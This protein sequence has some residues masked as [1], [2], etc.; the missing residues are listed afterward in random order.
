MISP[1]NGSYLEKDREIYIKV[2]AN[3][4]LSKAWVEILGKKKINTSLNGSGRI[5]EKNISLEE[6]RYNIIA[7]G[8]DIAGNI[9]KSLLYTITVVKLLKLNATNI[10]A[11]TSSIIINTSDVVINVSVLTNT[12][13]NI[14]TIVTS[15]SL[16]QDLNRTTSFG[17]ADKGAKYLEIRNNTAVRNVSRIRIEMHFTKAEIG[18]LDPNTVAL[19]Y[20][21]GSAWISTMEYENETIPDNRGG[22]FVYE[23][24]RFYDSA[25]GKGYVYAEVNHTSV[26]ALGGKVIP[27]VVPTP[28]A[29]GEYSPEAVLLTNSIDLALAEEL[30][31]KLK[32]NKIK[33]HIASANNFS[34]YKTKLYIIVLGGHKA[35]EGIGEIVSMMTTEEEKMN[36]SKGKVFIKKK[37]VFRKGQTVYIFAGANRFLTKEAWLKFFDSALKEIKYN[38]G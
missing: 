1:I 15:F 9:G 26:F 3:E 24:G 2:T 33:I 12:I 4:D 25:T 22:L 19:F 13:L 29:G 38:L 18:N 14:S 30:I 35:Y 34:I 10:M 21:N 16:Y 5:F 8:I 6:G 20:W 32:K 28:S 36:I 31:E 27:A 7:Y 37:S 11:N 17:K 23:A